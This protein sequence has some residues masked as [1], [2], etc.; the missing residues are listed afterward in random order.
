MWDKIIYTQQYE[1]YA[2]HHLKTKR[3]TAD[4]HKMRKQGFPRHLTLTK[5]PKLESN[6]DFD[7]QGR[8]QP[9]HCS[10]SCFP[11]KGWLLCAPVSKTFLE[12]TRLNPSRFMQTYKGPLVN[13]AIEVTSRDATVGYLLWIILLII[14]QNLFG[15]SKEQAW[16]RFINMFNDSLLTC[17]PHK[18]TKLKQGKL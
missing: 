10:S 5:K 9:C 17:P 4:S 15:I 6:R 11:R 1:T 7:F 14:F 13:I 18:K 16:L 2:Q 3:N 8:Q 12:V